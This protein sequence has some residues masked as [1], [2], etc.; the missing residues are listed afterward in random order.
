[1]KK[2]KENQQE[3]VNKMK[4]WFFQKTSKIDKPLGR[5]IWKSRQNYQYQE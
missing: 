1:M 3:K 2:K 5:L 4:Y